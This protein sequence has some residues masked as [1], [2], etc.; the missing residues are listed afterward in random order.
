[1]TTSDPV[2]PAPAPPARPREPIAVAAAR[3]GI[4]RRTLLRW[5]AG[6]AGV[7]ALPAI[8]FADRIAYA[9][10]TE[11]RLPVLWLNGQDCNG[12][13][14]GL[15]RASQPTPSQLI[16]DYLS[17]DYAE[18]LMAASGDT[19][20]GRLAATMD[21]Y[22]GQYV[23]VV[24]GSIATA[25][26]GVHCC[27]GGRSFADIVREV[28]AGALAVIAVGS[29]AADGGLPLAAGG[30]TGAVSVST[31]LSGLGTTIINLPGCPMNIENLTATLVQYITLGTWPET[32]NA[33]KPTF[34]YGSRVHQRCPRLPFFRAGQ[35]VRTW[36]DAGHQA[37]WCLRYVGCQGPRTYANCQTALF[38]GGTSFPVNAGAPCLGCASSTF[39]SGLDDSFSWT[40]PATSLSQATADTLT[41]S[42]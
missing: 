3:H 1:M 17:L 39:W 42:L 6:M 34:A 31:A 40:P 4:D 2:T 19:A 8:P 23:V 38:N 9:L 28:S 32:D 27:I 13:I 20:Q 15:L 24:E 37:G 10:D 36:G 18:L 26:N 29:C 30:V 33:G 14:E 41:A 12:D 22:A 5:S 35:Y 16:L 7:L 21:S 25:A 11:P